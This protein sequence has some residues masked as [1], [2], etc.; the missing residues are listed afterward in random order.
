MLTESV[1]LCKI[2]YFSLQPGA[3]HVPARHGGLEDVGMGSF[4]KWPCLGP[5]HSPTWSLQGCFSGSAGPWRGVSG[6]LAGCPNCQT[7]LIE[8]FV[9]DEDGL[10][11][12][13]VVAERVAVREGPS[14][15]AAAVSSLRRGVGPGTGRHQQH[16]TASQHSNC[17]SSHHSNASPTPLRL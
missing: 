12:S 10:F 17:N 11:S 5:L 7:W 3:E 14:L 1:Y 13:Q 4:G 9:G 8:P 6:A 2:S 16:L 15:G